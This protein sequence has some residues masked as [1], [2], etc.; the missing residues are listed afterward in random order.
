M[1]QP[2]AAP[3][4]PAAAPQHPEKAMTFWYQGYAFLARKVSFKLIC[5]IF[6]I[7]AVFTGCLAILNNV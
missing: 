5:I 1:G 2:A 6:S 7:E 4:P 3:H